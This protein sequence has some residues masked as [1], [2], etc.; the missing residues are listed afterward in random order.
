[1][2]DHV[3]ERVLDRC[4]TSVNPEELYLC[5][6]VANANEWLAP[7]DPASLGRGRGKSGR[8]LAKT[9]KPCLMRKES[10]PPA[11]D[12]IVVKTPNLSANKRVPTHQPAV[13]T[14][15]VQRCWRISGTKPIVSWPLRKPLAA[16][17]AVVPPAP[18]AVKTRAPRAVVLTPIT[19]RIEALIQRMATAGLPMSSNVVIATVLHGPGRETVRRSIERLSSAGRI[20][21]ETQP[22]MRRIRVLSTKTITA[23]GAC[24]TSGHAPYSLNPRGSVPPPAMNRPDYK[25]VEHQVF[26]Y[27]HE[28]QRMVPTQPAPT[29]QWSHHKI[30]CDEPSVPRY[31][32]CLEHG[33]LIFPGWKTKPPKLAI[34]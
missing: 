21:V 11:C 20:A 29:C 10:A 7:S 17:V 18:I 34:H 27:R 24:V 26:R 6:T 1:L 31:S 14:K 33:L 4:D 5:W 13:S 9:A 15:T 3:V 19:L 28:P 25:P 23:W 2:S 30:R 32:W 16:P 22:G 12:A 8:K